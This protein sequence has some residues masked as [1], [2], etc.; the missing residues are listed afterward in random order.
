MRHLWHP[1]NQT[2]F[3]RQAPGCKGPG[4]QPAPSEPPQGTQ[5]GFGCR[6]RAPR[7]A[8]SSRCRGPCPLRNAKFLRLPGHRRFPPLLGAAGPSETLPGSLQPVSWN[9]F[10]G[11]PDLLSVLFL[12]DLRCPPLQGWGTPVPPEAGGSVCAPG[13]A[14][15]Q[16]FLERNLCPRP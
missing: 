7:L 15:P 14:G 3:A 11:F 4:G 1:V 8:L 5:Q 12:Q 2:L 16:S 6:E 13:G 10:P 9:P